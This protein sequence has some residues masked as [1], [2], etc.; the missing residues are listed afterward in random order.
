M[1]SGLWC[2]RRPRLRHQAVMDPTGQVV[3]RA[4]PP[5][6]WARPIELPLSVNA[7]QIE[8]GAVMPR[9]FRS[10]VDQTT[11]TAAPPVRAAWFHGL[12]GENFL[13]VEL[14]EA[15]ADGYAR[16]L[17]PRLVA[18]ALSGREAPSH[19]ALAGLMAA[20]IERDRKATVPTGAGRGWVLAASG[21][22]RRAAGCGSESGRIASSSPPSGARWRRSRRT[23]RVVDPVRDRLDRVR[24]AHRAHRRGSRPDLVGDAAPPGRG[25]FR[26]AWQRGRDGP[27]HAVQPDGKLRRHRAGRDA[28]VPACSRGGLRRRAGARHA[29]V[30]FRD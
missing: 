10:F 8:S 3:L 7:A 23:L 12:G 21:W 27:L 5:E 30:Q 20:V 4:M 15:V 24:A 26:H 1:R 16:A 25:G 28:P 9:E 11:D 2:G 19:R 6:E 22:R 18:L 17:L 13:L 14:D 29:D